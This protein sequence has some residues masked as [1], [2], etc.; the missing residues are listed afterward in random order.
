[1]RTFLSLAPDAQTAVAIEK[2]CALC[3]PSLARK[4]PVQNYHVTVAFLGE[5]NSE[6]LISL[7]EMLDQLQGS[8]FELLFN[9]VKYWPDSTLLWLGAQSV[10]EPAYHLADKCKNIAN[11]AGLRASSRRYEPH[12]TLARKTQ[13]PPGAPLLDPDFSVQFDSL[14]LMQ[15]IRER[16]GV[17]YIE[18]GAWPLI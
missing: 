14:Q 10:P 13:S 9:E 15:S 11:R 5:T 3:W 8:A 4:V 2:W 7:Q 12:L 18:L 6:Q 16:S 17:R 1:M